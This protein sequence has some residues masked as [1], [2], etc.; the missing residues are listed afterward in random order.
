M[1]KK[2]RPRHCEGVSPWQSPGTGLLISAV[3]QEIATAFGL[4][5]TE[6]TLGYF[7]WLGW[8]SIE[9]DREGKGI[10]AL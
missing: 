8:E 2:K 3:Y 7:F 9:P 4:A 6:V 1:T 10:L 5:M